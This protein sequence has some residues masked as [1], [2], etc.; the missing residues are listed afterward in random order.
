M[1]ILLSV[2][3]AVLLLAP[4]VN[5]AET[6][7]LTPEKIAIVKA[8]CVAA[9][10]T[11]QQVKYSDAAN[12]VNRG[13]S[14]ERLISHLILPMNSRAAAN[15]FSSSAASLAGITTRY[16]QVL[17][18]FKKHYEDY[19]DALAATLRTKCQDKPADFYKNLTE[20]RK[21]RTSLSSDVSELA[22]LMENYHQAVIK[23]RSEVH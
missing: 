20:V 6:V 9:Q 1:R 16:Q 3:I 8:N 13:Q 12:R 5:A 17:S 14:Y 19:D 4:V 2:F 22:E 11:L 10:V 23:L 21:Q 18:N 15:G 7:E